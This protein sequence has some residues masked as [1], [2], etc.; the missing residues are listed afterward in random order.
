MK[1][2][3]LILILLFAAPFAANADVIDTTP[4]EFQFSC[5]G[6]ASACGQTFG[7]SFTVT[8]S[9]TRLESV[10]F[11]LISYVLPDGSTVPLNVILRI[12]QWD[13]SDR[14]GSEL[15][16]SDSIQLTGEGVFFED[17]SVGIDLTTGLQYIAYLDAS[18][19]GNATSGRERVAWGF[20]LNS[21]DVYAGGGFFYELTAGSN[22]WSSN[23]RDASFRAVLSPTTSVPEPGTLALLGAGL[24]G[25]G[26]V[27]R[28]KAA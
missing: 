25:I 6:A 22:N 17:F 27:R 3:L 18:G 2:S 24:I 4:G 26:F 19:Q 9:D 20:N 23:S 5:L 11:E 13:G 15:F 7:Q 8:G 1:N 21:S 28:R 12:F 10:G 14:V 16:G